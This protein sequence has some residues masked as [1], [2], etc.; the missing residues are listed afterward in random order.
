MLGVTIAA[1]SLA[2]VIA[3]IRWPLDDFI[4]YWSAGRLNAAGSN[5][6]DPALMLREQTH[7]GWPDPKPIMMYNPPWTLAL[8]M[9]M[10]AA[11]FGFARS[12]WL[13]LQLLFTLWSVSQL[14]ILY[15]GAREGRTRAWFLGLLWSPTV[16]ALRFGQLGPVI[17]LG[18][19]GFL[20]CV[21]Q[22]RD[23]AAGTFLALTT[24]KPQFVAL[25]WLPVVL[26]AVADR[27]WKVLAGAAAAV[28]GASG[29]ALSTNLHVFA[30]YLDLMSAAPPTLAFESPNIATVLRAF[31][32]T[33]GSWP[34]YVPT[35]V[36]AAAILRLWYRR[37]NAW[38]WRD[39]LPA[40]VILS[41][42]LTS[43]GGWAFDLVVLL[44]PIV[45]LAAILSR[46]PRKARGVIGGAVFLAVSLLAFKMHQMRVPQAGFLWMTPVVAVAWWT[47][48]RM[49]RQRTDAL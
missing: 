17:L 24:V 36:G 14:W 46:S 15:G 19:V 49:A 45:A 10:G 25:V 8:A 21:V 1:L 35:V 48:S 6:Y 5:P 33:K 42:L 2:L 31:A 38:D 18:L 41:C 28:I 23:F 12:I 30:Q 3:N 40:L 37:R 29:I 13:P 43:Y 47:L 7:I 26:W 32:G 16:L 4:E 22:R 20:G 44:V 9:P 39:R 34:Q 11:E 27:R